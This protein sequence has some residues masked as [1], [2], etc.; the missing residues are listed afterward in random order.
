MWAAVG[1]ERRAALLKRWSG[2]CVWGSHAGC[3]MMRATD[4]ETRVETL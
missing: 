2:L 4:D 3:I 1:S